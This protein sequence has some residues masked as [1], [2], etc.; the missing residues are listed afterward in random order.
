MKHIGEIVGFS[1]KN[2]GKNWLGIVT[3]VT[4]GRIGVVWISGSPLRLKRVYWYT[5]DTLEVL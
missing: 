5:D 4:M 3:K 1:S 2:M